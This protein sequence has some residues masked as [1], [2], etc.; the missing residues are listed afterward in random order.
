MAALRILGDWLLGRGW[1]EA[2]VQVEVTTAGKADSFLGVAHVARTR[3]AHQVTV[4]ALYIL[5]CRAYNNR[6]TDTEDEPVG[7]DKWCSKTNESCPQIHYWATVMLCLLVQNLSPGS[8]LWTTPTMSA[9]SWFISVTLLN[10][11][12]NNLI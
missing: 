4:A 9:G 8:L 11:H 6:A 2:L 3:F 1:V 10:Y 5:Q 12:R 7:F